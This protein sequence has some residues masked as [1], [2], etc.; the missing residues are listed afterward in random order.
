MNT[1]LVSYYKDRAAEYEKIYSKPERQ[2]DLL[3]GAA[4]LQTIFSEK[5]VLEI[6]CGTGYWTEKIAAT[7]NQVLATDI[8]DAVI[9]IAKSKTYDPASITFQVADLYAL[10]APEKFEHLFGGFIWSHIKLE[11]LGAFL[12]AVESLVE[13]GGIIVFMDNNYVEGSNLPVTH[14]DDAGNTYQTRNLEDGT[15]HL[16]LKNF[17][18]E[19]F[20]RDLLKD[21]T[22]D[23]SFIQLQYYWIMT[24][25][26]RLQLPFSSCP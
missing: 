23:L 21:R 6:A 12:D 5:N 7:A 2:N 11:D 24:Y 1:N 13:P 20:I 19:S 3:A 14:T 17:P 22:S 18:S 16:V 8:N 9:E 10:N 25:K 26:K 15:Q 4:M